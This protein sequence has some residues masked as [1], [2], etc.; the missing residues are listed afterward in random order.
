MDD[1]LTRRNRTIRWIFKN[2]LLCTYDY[3]R[4]KINYFFNKRY[5]GA[6]LASNMVPQERKE[7]MSKFLERELLKNN[8][9]DFKVLEIGSW[10]GGSTILW[11]Q[12]LKKFNKGKVFCIDTWK[13]SPNIPEF[14]SNA[15]KKDKIFKLFIHNISVDKLDKIIKPLR[16]S[17]DDITEILKSNSFDFIFVDGDHSYSQSKK[18]F[19]NAIRLCKLNGII[20]GDDLDINLEANPDIIDIEYA[21]KN[22]EI[23]YVRDLKSKI[24]YHPGVLL[25]T[26]EIFGKV[27]F[28]KGF[29]AVKKVENGWEKIDS[30]DFEKIKN[31]KDIVPI[32]KPSVLTNT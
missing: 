20:C 4:Y 18:D 22:R 10:G 5:F 23:N 21:K 3:F 1:I 19:I 17:S 30:D 12:V 24:W 13:S 28:Y 15:T 9:P 31:N 6:Y 26:K 7:F 2:S 27:S 25:A 11:A 14:I 8:N 32:T 29:W 16:G